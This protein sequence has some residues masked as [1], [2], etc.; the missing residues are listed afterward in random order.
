[1]LRNLGELDNRAVKQQIFR[2]HVWAIFTSHVASTHDSKTIGTTFSIGVNMCLLVVTSD[3]GQRAIHFLGCQK[4]KRGRVPVVSQDNGKQGM[5]DSLFEWF[6]LPTRI[7]MHKQV[8]QVITRFQ[9]LAYENINE[10]SVLR[11]ADV[12]K[13]VHSCIWAVDSVSEWLW[14][15]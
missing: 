10:S 12:E 2:S 14:Y 13:Q 4:A 15:K 11:V 9:L 5:S 8:I 3:N 1:M 7:F 6:R